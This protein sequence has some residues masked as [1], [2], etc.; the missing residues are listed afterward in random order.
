[1]LTTISLFFFPQWCLLQTL[2]FSSIYLKM[3]KQSLCHI[4]IIGSDIAK[5]VALVN[6]DHHSYLK[7]VFACCLIL[8]VAWDQQHARSGDLQE[9][10]R[11]SLSNL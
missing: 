2:L 8:K 4:I 7:N 9:V 1:M 3:L 11:K 6:S 10:K 5:A